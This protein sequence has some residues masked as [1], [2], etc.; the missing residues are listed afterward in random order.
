MEARDLVSLGWGAGGQPRTAGGDA[1]CP[2]VS[3]QEDPSLCSLPLVLEGWRSIREEERCAAGL[4]EPMRALLHS[5]L[6]PN[7]LSL[8]RS[9][10]L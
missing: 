8:S 3:A 6:S 9:E 10:M 2:W 7:S 5:L 1:T 4:R